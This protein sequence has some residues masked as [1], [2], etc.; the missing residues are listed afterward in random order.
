MILCQ[1][2]PFWT[3][4]P[5]H[6]A[7]K[8]KKIFPSISQSSWRILLDLSSASSISL[9]APDFL[10][11]VLL[12]RKSPFGAA[13]AESEQRD[14]LQEPGM[15]PAGRRARN[16]PTGPHPELQ[17]LQAPSVSRFPQPSTCQS[18]AWMCQLS[19]GLL[20][21]SESMQW[22]SRTAHPRPQHGKASQPC[23]P[24]RRAQQVE[25]WAQGNELC[26]PTVPSA[27]L[28]HQLRECQENKQLG[29]SALD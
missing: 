7:E 26:Q 15:S 19:P 21:R 23:P 3:T 9:P 4:Y 12:W 2:F 1:V 27:G 24:A 6:M 5:W 11:S 13:T 17:L 28:C 16:A 25:G 18:Q 8:G 20:T 10:A 22:Q 29:R 14:Q